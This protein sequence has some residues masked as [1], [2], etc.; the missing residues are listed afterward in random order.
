LINRQQLFPRH[1]YQLNF[2]LFS[3]DKK[4]TRPRGLAAEVLNATVSNTNFFIDNVSHCYHNQNIPE[5]KA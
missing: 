4:G 5:E 3:E 1:L 2:V